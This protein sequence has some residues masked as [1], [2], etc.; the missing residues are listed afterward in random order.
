MINRLKLMDTPL[1]LC[2]TTLRSEQHE[3]LQVGSIQEGIH[4]T[5]HSIVQIENTP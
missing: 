5:H 2:F 3:I 4:Q 1:V